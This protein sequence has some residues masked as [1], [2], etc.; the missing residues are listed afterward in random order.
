MST[1]GTVNYTDGYGRAGGPN[2]ALLKDHAYLQVS[3][4]V[5]AS[6]GT[7][8]TILP[9]AS[10]VTANPESFYSIWFISAANDDTDPWRALLWDKLP[11]DGPDGD[12]PHVAGAADE[13]VVY[14]LSP[15][16]YGTQ[17]WSSD[18]PLKLRV[19]AGVELDN[20]DVPSSS[21]QMLSIGYTLT[22]PTS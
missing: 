5:T 1:G 13:D 18:T 11:T 7:S 8:A 21:E 19:G 4:Y 17:I 2:P 20:I 15:T 3:S 16:T 10:A 6:L 14:A 9:S 12:T 22:T